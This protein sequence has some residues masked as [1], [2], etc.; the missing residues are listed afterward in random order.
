MLARKLL[1]LTVVVACCVPALA[2]DKKKPILPADV[3]QARTVLVIVDPNA[4][5][6][7]TD[8]TADR[9]AREDVEQA[10]T[11]WGRF[12]VVQD[13]STADLVI[14]V[15][16]GNGKIV[17]STIGGTPINGIPP[18]YGGS[19]RSQTA[20]TT[21]AG[22]RWGRSS[23][24]NDPSNPRPER[25]SPH[26]QVEAGPSEDMFVVYRGNVDNPNSNPLD[27]FP[28]WRYLQ[29]NALEPPSVPA[30]AAFR[31]AIAESEKQLASKP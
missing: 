17:Q 5:V 14:T 25:E 22:V 28:V 10:L 2:K 6:D 26:P 24:P 15:R 11:K 12:E 16:K 20:T 7:P 4:G 13:G 9:R 21:R 31:K 30:V 19:T 1:A 23:M 27:A 3:L 29:K 18:A 8:P